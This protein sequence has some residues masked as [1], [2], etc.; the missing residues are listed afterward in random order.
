MDCSTPGFPVLHH[1]E[2]CPSSCPLKRWCHPTVSSSVILFSYFPQSHPAS[3]SFPM[4]QLFTSGGQSVRTLAS[5]SVLP[6]S[7]QGWFPLRLTDLISLLSKGLL[8]VFSRITVGKHQFFSTLP[9]LL[10]SSHICL[11]MTTRKTIAL[12]IWTFVGKVMSLF[13]NT[14]CK[15]VTAFLPR[16]NHILIWWLQSPSVVILEPKKRKVVIASTFSPSICHKVMGLDA[17]IFAFSYWVLSQLFQS[18]LSLSSR[19]CLV[20]LHFLS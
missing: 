17:M 3:G 1:P 18:P 5:V 9:S 14:L 10:S 20:P 6:M 19:G 16:S 4:S 15:F 7:A 2:V 8:R 12:T 11:Y 13:F